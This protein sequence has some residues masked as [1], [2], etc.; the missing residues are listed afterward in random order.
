MPTQTSALWPGGCPKLI[1]LDTVYDF[2]AYKQL[3][4]D[5]LNVDDKEETHYTKLKF[6]TTRIMQRNQKCDW[7]Q[8]WWVDYSVNKTTMDPHYHEAYHKFHCDICFKYNI[9]DCFHIPY[10]TVK[11]MTVGEWSP[12]HNENKTLKEYMSCHYEWLVLTK[13]KHQIILGKP[14]IIWRIF[15]KAWDELLYKKHRFPGITVF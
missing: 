10:K 3:W 6:S 4:W 12:F 1:F 14:M 11:E 15:T 13:V 9:L 7:I 8:K 2:A 5:F